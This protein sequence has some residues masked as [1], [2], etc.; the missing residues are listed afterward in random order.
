[1]KLRTLFATALVFALPAP[2]PASAGPP[3][4]S[5]T[6]LG[7][8]FFENAPRETMV[9]V[10]KAKQAAYLL[11][12]KGDRPRVVR[13]FDRVLL[14]ENGGDKVVEGDKRTPEGVYYIQRYIPGKELAALYGEG[15]FPLNYPN[16]VDRIEDKTGYGIWLHGVNEDDED[17]E[18]TQGCV[19][20]NDGKLNALKQR[21]DIGTPV[22]ITQEA[23]FLPPGD[24]RARKQ[25]LLTH[26][27][28]FLNAWENN[29]F[30]A[31]KR[32]VH[33][34]FQTRG[35]QGAE[36]YLAQKRRLM[37]AYPQRRVEA[38]NLRV[39]KENGQRVVYDFNQFYCAAN[40]AAYGRKRLYFKRNDGR[41]QAVAEE[42]FS[43]PVWPLI[44]DRVREFV[45]GWKAAW[46]DED[47]TAYMARYAQTF[48]H[49]GRDRAAWRDY[50]EGVFARRTNIRVEIAN[51]W[52]R[53]LAG[54]RYVVGF[55]QRFK[56]DDYNDYG[57]KTLVL[58]GCPGA[59]RI[60]AEHWRPLP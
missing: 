9:L 2:A 41:P 55:D 26:L 29:N 21:L 22:I 45:E 25:Q 44:Q 59:F 20:F 47:M 11:R 36:A 8:A 7:N 57:V 14:G 35:G 16:I 49:N 23:D 15:A 52:I 56:S 10:E 24:Y 42:Y 27:D 1:M 34:E 32:Q 54:N 38:D 28:S 13:Q 17:K 46:E 53:Q 31:L 30:Q 6:L 58:E 33:P 39:Y 48:R 43:K 60:A 18:A 19:A 3:A 5:N 51:L 40:L 12:N 37:E 4:G 50:K